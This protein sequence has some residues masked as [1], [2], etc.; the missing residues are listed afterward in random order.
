M[1][2]KNITREQV[3]NNA[4]PTATYQRSYTVE[5]SEM[6]YKLLKGDTKLVRSILEANNFSYTESHDWNVLWASSS[7]KSYL[8]EGLNEYQRINHFP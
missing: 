6:T 7:C 1:P 2:I 5:N 3:L 4:P 8:Y